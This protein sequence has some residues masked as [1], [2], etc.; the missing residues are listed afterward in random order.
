MFQRLIALILLTGLLPILILIS[1]GQLFVF[2]KILFHQLRIGKDESPFTLYKFQ[3]L[4]PSEGGA[5]D[6]PLWGK[7]LRRLSL[8]EIPQLFNILLGQM[9]FIG[10][11]PLLPQYL[12]HYN[13]EQ[14]KRHRLR[15]GLTGW[16]QVNGRYELTWKQQF[17]LDVWY[18]ENKSFRL[19][20]KILMV[21]FIKIIQPKGEQ[22]HLREPFNGTN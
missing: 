15:P 8:D 18:V 17:E 5:F 16:A 10:P 12:E 19:D 6:T 2:K 7:W 14:R 21:T 11:R 4:L 3:T 1:I 9:N 20:L 13:S 22:S